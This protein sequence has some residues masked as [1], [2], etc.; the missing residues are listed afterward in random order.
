MGNLKKV[1]EYQKISVVNA[2]PVI[3]SLAK[4]M[5]WIDMT[6]DPTRKSWVV[7]NKVR[8][9]LDQ[10]PYEMGDGNYWEQRE[11]I[12]DFLKRW[13]ILDEG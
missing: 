3:A 12:I 13:G 10:K 4:L 5:K 9:M 7:L 2:E 8:F 6:A 11:Y 1:T